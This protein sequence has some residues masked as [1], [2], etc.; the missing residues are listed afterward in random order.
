MPGRDL[1]ALADQVGELAH[2]RPAD[3]DVVVVAVERQH[4]A[5]QED[6]AVEVLLERLHDRVA[7]ARQLGGDLVRELEL[8]AH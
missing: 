8:R 6:L 4:V 3:R 7:R 1:V 5:A 2:D